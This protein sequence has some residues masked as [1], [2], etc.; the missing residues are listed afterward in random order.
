M[1]RDEFKIVSAYGH[2]EIYFCG[3]FLFSA[4]TYEE[5]ERDIDELLD[6]E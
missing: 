2:Y 3:Q 5:A 4:D 6:E 1:S